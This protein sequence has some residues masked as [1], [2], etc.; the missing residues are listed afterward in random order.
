MTFIL[1]FHYFKGEHRYSNPRPSNSKR[2]SQHGATLSAVVANNIFGRIR[3]NAFSTWAASSHSHFHIFVLVSPCEVA[4]GPG[5]LT[6]M[7]LKIRFI[8]PLKK[9]TRSNPP[10]IEHGLC[11]FLNCSP[12][13]TRVAFQ[14]FK[15]LYS[16]LC[17]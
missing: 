1:S 12:V 16:Q 8:F 4:S 6:L 11:L 3:Q 13:Q 10:T 5:L 9:N 7:P 2:F 15:K 17:S 14:R